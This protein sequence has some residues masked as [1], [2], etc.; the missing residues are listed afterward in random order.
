MLLLKY[1]VQVQR[2]GKG[3]YGGASVVC[4]FS[5]KPRFPWKLPS[6]PAFIPHW[7]ELERATTDY[8]GGWNKIFILSNFHNKEGPRKR[9]LEMSVKLANQQYMS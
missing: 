7:P 6:T 9:A 3:E 5:R 8:K 1:R 4:L 2:W